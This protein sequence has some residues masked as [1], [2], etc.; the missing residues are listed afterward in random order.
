MTITRY[1]PGTIYLGGPRTEIGDMA[2]KEVITPGHLVERVNTAGVWQWQKHTTAGGPGSRSV[3]TEQ[4]MLNKGVD[5]NYAA[6]DLMEVTEAA[7]GTNMWMFIASG[8]NIAYGDQLES[9]GN[10]T[11]RKQADTGIPLFVALETKANV[12]VLTR[13]RVEVLP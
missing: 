5:D 9:A 6:G 12:V 7:G 8:Q 1:D 2:A 11:L 13:I 4:S 3:A 10:G